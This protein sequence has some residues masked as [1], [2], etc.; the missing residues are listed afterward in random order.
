MKKMVRRFWSWLKKLYGGGGSDAGPNPLRSV[1]W[2][3]PERPTPQQLNQKEWPPRTP[4][5]QGTSGVRDRPLAS[6]RPTAPVRKP[7][8][9]PTRSTSYDYTPSRD[10]G[11]GF[12]DGLVL[13][14]ILSDATRPATPSPTP[15]PTLA[16]RTESPPEPTSAFRTGGTV[17]SGGFRTGGNESTRD[18]MPVEKPAPESSY[19]KFDPSYSSYS[20]PETK[21]SSYS[22][23]SSSSSCYSSS[24]S[25]SSSSSS[26]S[27]DSGSSSS[28]SSGE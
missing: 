7:A 20:A 8:P 25:S 13:G 9:T 27:S 3:E 14:H 24:D 21:S 11:P 17:E 16:Y 10:S 28:S 23:T 12:V 26:S 1:K 19:T 6:S 15:T 5:N 22:D 18:W 4:P 2:P